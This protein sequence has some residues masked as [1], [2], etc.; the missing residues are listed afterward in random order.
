MGI[1]DISGDHRARHPHTLG[2]VSTAA[3]MIENSLVLAEC[4]QHTVVKL[5][6]RASGVGSVAQGLL[7]FDEDGWLVGANRTGLALM[8]LPTLPKGQTHWSALFREALHDLESGDQSHRHLLH[9]HSGNALY[10]QGQ[11]PHTQ[12]LHAA[13]STPLLT[14]DALSRLDAGDATCRRAADMARKV[15]DKGIPLLIGG[16]SGVGKDWFA[17]AVHQCSQRRDRAWVAVNCA[18]LPESLIEAELFGYAP[19]AFTGASRQGS[20]GR[21]READGG[22]LFLDEIGDMPL[23]AQTRLLR[24]LQERSVTAVGS[25]TSTPVDFNLICASHQDLKQAVTQ[26]RFRQDLYYRINGLSLTLPPLRERTDFVA[27]C[28]RLLTQAAPHTHVAIA[29]EVMEQLRGFAWPGNLRQLSHVLRCAIA[30]L[31]DDERVIDWSHM[32][33]DI[34]QEL[35]A[36]P[37]VRQDTP[38]QNWAD[39][40]LKAIDMALENTRGNVS[41]AARQ[42]GISRQTLYRKL[43]ERA[44]RP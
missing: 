21:I 12:R 29:P 36:K 1:L 30:L 14:G 19:G 35:Q 13:P 28:E 44:A 39:L 38:A 7:A 41:A 20:V 11:R 18:A 25:G 23:S 8:D 3:Q 4:R 33:D 2:L 27:L 43:H 10:A 16:E 34:T 42:L 15:M 32:P 5:H 26:G 31:D 40:S 17:Q 24:V 37:A 6:P 9:T 22:T